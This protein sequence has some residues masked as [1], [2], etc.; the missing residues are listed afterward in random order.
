MA[1]LLKFLSFT[2]GVRQLVIALIISLPSL[3]NVGTLLFIFIFIYAIIGMTL[4]G[5]IKQQG[6]LTDMENF[7]DF[8]KSMLL[9]FRLSTAAGWDDILESLSVKPPNC[10]PLFKGFVNG[11]CGQPVVAIVYIT[12]YIFVVFLIM[13]NMYIAIILE[14]VRSV[15]E[16][17]EFVISGS[18]IDNFYQVWDMF[19]P[20]GAQTFPYNQLSDFVA[21]LDKPLCIPQPNNMKILRMGIRVRK[22]D[23]VHLFDVM[24]ALVKRALEKEGQLE[25][26]DVFDKIVKKMEA[27]FGLWRTNKQGHTKADTEEYAAIVIQ[28]AYR[29]HKAK[30]KFLRTLERIRGEHGERQFYQGPTEICSLIT[31]PIVANT[32]YENCNR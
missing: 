29:K 27:R 25:S 13:I 14:N 21:H 28:K 24:K 22:G 2:K 19:S 11:N 30:Q 4:F 20:N 1:R 31:N 9:L 12:S 23:K 7:E 8:G 32:F 18:T 16:E 26:S 5:N 15:Q 17:E 3:L 6:S 10:D